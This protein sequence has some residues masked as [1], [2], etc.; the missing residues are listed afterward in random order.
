MPS[1]NLQGESSAKLAPPG[2]AAA[3]RNCVACGEPIEE[4]VEGRPEHCFV[5][6][7]HVVCACADEP[8]TR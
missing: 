4:V 1:A 7:V 2:N 6:A 3:A 5:C 8:E